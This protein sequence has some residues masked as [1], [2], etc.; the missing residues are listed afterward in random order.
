MDQT[1]ATLALESASAA[2]NQGEP[3]VLGHPEA[4]ST[5]PRRYVEV[6]IVVIALTVVIGLL[7]VGEP[8]FVP[9][10]I[11]IITSYLLG[12]AVTAL[13]RAHIPRSVGAGIVLSAVVASGVSGMYAL[14]DDAVRFSDQLP[15]L[16]KKL[17]QL[18]HDRLGGK[19]N[20]LASMH[21]AAT[22][23]ERAAKEASG[24]SEARAGASAASA[25]GTARL[26]NVL[27]AGTSSAL[28]RTSELL[29]AL[30]IAYFLLAAGDT[31]RRKLVRIAGPSLARR[32]LT[33]EVLDEINGQ[34]Q[35][36]MFVLL[37][38]NVLIGLAMWGL[39]TAW[40]LENAAL[41]GVIA[42]ILHVIPYAGTAVLTAAAGVAALIQLESVLSAGLVAAATI[43]IAVAIGIG[44]NTWLSGRFARMNPVVVFAGLLFFGWLWGIWGLLL[45]VPLLAVIKAI[46]ERVEEMR[47]I[48]ELMR[49]G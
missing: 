6:A 18:A 26:G 30:L 43:G 36:Y 17:R 22:E 21:K 24:Q 28:L 11:G 39:F 32:R 40:G 42:A 23:L 49:E 34:I 46:A 10:L 45:A 31:F 9:L 7:K 48:A 29:L 33:I 44:L 38:T 14:G 15:S 25:G 12:P 16:A 19:P 37:V 4:D 5:R 35:R 2:T 3:V 20:P 13:H 8:F 47:P 1:N 27:M 41:W